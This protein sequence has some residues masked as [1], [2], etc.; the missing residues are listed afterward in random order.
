M[1]ALE[2]GQVIDSTVYSG[3]PQDHAADHLNIITDHH[4]VNLPPY[5]LTSSRP[6]LLPSPSLSFLPSADIGCAARLHVNSHRNERMS[7]VECSCQIPVECPVVAR[8][9]VGAS[10]TAYLLP[11][12]LTVHRNTPHKHSHSSPPAL[13]Y[14]RVRSHQHRRNDVMRESHPRDVKIYATSR[15]P[16]WNKVFPRIGSRRSQRARSCF[17]G[18]GLHPLLSPSL[19]YHAR[20]SSSHTPSCYEIVGGRNCYPRLQDTE[21]EDTDIHHSSFSV[22]AVR[23]SSPSSDHSEGTLPCR[24]CCRR[25]R[26]DVDV[27]DSGDSSRSTYGSSQP[28]DP[29]D[30]SSYDSGVYRDRG[31]ARAEDQI[32]AVADGACREAEADEVSKR[33]VR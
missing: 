22:A 20:S 5:P 30:V 7:A 23:G 10:A 29:S 33:V 19:P 3:Y 4:H 13:C 1:I 25:D 21:T 27:S 2:G 15:G 9:A 16:A 17:S 18:E 8:T 24:I 26:T 31:E 6:T 12:C 32:G 11:A 14:T 28:R